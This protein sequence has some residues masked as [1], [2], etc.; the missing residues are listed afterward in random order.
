MTEI[1][2]SLKI[3]GDVN[4]YGNNFQKREFV[5]TTEGQYPQD[6]KLELYQNDCGKIDSFSVGDPLCASYNLKGNEYNGKYYVNLQAWKIAPLVKEDKKN[7]P[8][9]PTAKD[10]PEDLTENISELADAPF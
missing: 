5:L 1:T 2:G 6:I 4:T 7:E 9:A 10:E 3:I 8:G